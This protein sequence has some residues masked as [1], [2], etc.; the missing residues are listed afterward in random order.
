MQPRIESFLSARLHLSPQIAGDR[1]TFI[2]NLSGRLSLYGMYY[3]G[4]LPE[5]LLPPDISMQNPEL[6]G[7]RSFFVFPLLDKILVMLDRD[8]DENYQPMLVPMLG[9]FPEPAFDNFFKDHRV[10]LSG[11]DI[12]RNIVYFNAERRDAPI[13]EAYRGDLRTNKLEK[14]DQSEWGAFPAGNNEDHSKVFISDSYSMG[15]GVLYLME[16]G[17]KSLLLG[18]PLDQRKPGE[19]VP[20]T[21]LGSA[22]FTPGGNAALV[23]TAIF[24]DK[25]SLGLIDFSRPGELLPVKLD[26]QVHSGVGELVA[27]SQLKGSHYAVHFN[28]DGCSWLYEGIFNEEKRS[29][30]LRHVIV[31]DGDLAGGVLEHYYY[32]KAGDRFVL[33]FSTASSPIQIFT[34]EAKDRLTIVMHTDE[35][36]LGIPDSQL[37]QGQ[38]ASFVS[39]DGTRVSAR[40]YLP[41]GSL[42]YPGPRPLIYYIHGGPQGQERPDFAWFSMPLIQFLTLRGFAVF[43]PNVR[44]STGYGLDYTKQV[45]R[46]WGGRDRLDHVHAMTKV[47]PKDKRLDLKRAAVVGRSYGGYMTLT[48]AGRHPQLWSAA[49]DMFGPYDLQTFYDRLPETWK[50]Y[51]RIA[52]ADPGTAAGRA[53]LYERSPKTWLDAL[54]CPLLVIQGRNDPRVVA[55]ESEELVSDLKKKGKDIDILLFED[56]G[57][58]VLKYTNRVTCYNAIADFFAKYLKP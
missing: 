14:L 3:G 45:D 24:D 26:G 1:I 43:V 55:K 19:T 12:D 42:G 41:A 33:S 28:I 15:D 46:D 29:L 9:G 22:E 38:D 8:G 48:L 4:S 18:K 10:H 50:P 44:G 11:C 53:F 7:G 57:H 47:L 30:S 13:Q 54:A 2:S 58:D 17:L 56:E 40:L 39:F 27:C 35:R 21:G 51:Y 23:T 5:P 32:D 6:I 49:C 37:A 16:Q 25:Y 52:L 31:G 34:V 36:L 20:L